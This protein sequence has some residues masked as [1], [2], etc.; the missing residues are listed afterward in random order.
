MVIIVQSE[1]KLYDFTIIA[2]GV[3][4]NKFVTCLQNVATGKA[5]QLLLHGIR[6]ESKH[7]ES[8]EHRATTRAGEPVS[9]FA[10]IAEK[11]SPFLPS[12]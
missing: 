9:I 3:E 2:A 8:M 6:F 11:M 10:G 5:I 7:L 12:W 4:P 1:L